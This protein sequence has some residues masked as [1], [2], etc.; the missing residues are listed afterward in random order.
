MAL[1]E[2]AKKSGAEMVMVHHGMFWKN[3]SR[4]LK[5]NLKERVAFLLN[6]N[7]SL[8]AYHLP[9]DAHRVVGNNAQIIKILGAHMKEAFGEYKG[10]QIGFV[11]MFEKAQPLSR[12]IDRLKLLCPEGPVIFP[13]AS[14]KVRRFAVVSGGAGDLYEQAVDAGMDLFITGEVAEPAQ[15]L[16][17]ESGTGFMALGHY[18]SEKGGIMALGGWVKTRFKVEVEFIDIPNPA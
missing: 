9:L 17:E 10:M 11:G 7:L 5:G 18:N 13:G 14:K 2:E 8:V 1:L 15:A 12:I 16:A 3:Q 6:N 4:V